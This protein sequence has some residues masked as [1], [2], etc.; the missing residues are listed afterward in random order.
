V[1]ASIARLFG[2]VLVL[3]ALLV[4]FT[5]RWT[6]FEAEALRDN[7]NNR[8]ELLAEQLI[9]RGLIRDDDGRVLARSPAEPQKRFGRRYPTGPLFAQAVG[10]TS[11]DRGRAGLEDFYNDAL[12]G[13]ATNAID[14]V[15]R[16]FGPAKVGDD[17]R[18]TL[19]E[20]AQK[21]ATDALASREQKGAVVALEL[22]T[23][24]VKV[25]AAKPSFDPNGGDCGAN[26][27]LATQGLF[28]PGSTMKAVTASAAIDSGKYQPDSRVSGRNG[29]EI[30]GAPLNNFGDEDFGDIDLTFALTNS[31]NTVWAEVAEKLGKRTMAEYMEKFGF[32]ADPP[33]DYPDNQ[34]VASGVNKGRKRLV[35]PTS[36]QVDIGRVAI[37]QGDLEVTPLQMATVAQTIGNGGVRMEPRLVAKVVDQ[38]GRTVDEPLPQEA[39]RVMSED[40]AQKVGDMMRN[41]VK[42]GTGTAAALEG[43]DV[44]GKTG[45]AE[46]NLQGLN[47]PWFIGFTD[48]FAVAVVFERVQGGT[49]GT[50][51]AP[52]AKA[53]LESLGE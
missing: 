52:V 45:T 36:D 14:A 20:K 12:T 31:V 22:K 21:V 26:L 7:S 18:T 37:G 30:S 53:V 13:R 51:S 34:M 10:C 47:D 16:L 24:A 6:V 23:G 38:D 15:T 33:M 43:V 41:V 4:G 44:A 40:S 50:I 46:V 9:K 28:P 2:L 42:E 25:L 35:K 11:L 48:R 1:N 27:N 29:K 19:S 5:S 3:F 49:G 32:Y 8:R 39:E 17:L